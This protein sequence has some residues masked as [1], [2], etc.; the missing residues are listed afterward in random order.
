VLGEGGHD[1]VLTFNTQSSSQWDGFRHVA[2]PVHHHYNGVADG[3]HGMHHWA[4]RGLAGRAVLVDVARHV[5]IDCSAS[6][7]ITTDELDATLAAQGV[8]IEPGDVLLLRTGWVA[9][10]RSTDEATRQ[11]LPGALKAPGLRPGD[12][13]LQWLWDHHVAAVGADNPSLEAWPPGSHLTKEQRDAVRTDP[14]RLSDVFMHFALLPLLGIPIGE[15]WDLDP[16][17]ADC[18]ADGRYAGLFTSAPLRVHA[19]VASP[20][21]AIVLK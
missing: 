3:D 5:E 14:S 13:M 9:W 15:L 18:A 20:P 12:D 1:D 21:N 6:Q 19:G 8:E 17:A 11:A 2:H 10:Y 16:L 4:A 7:T